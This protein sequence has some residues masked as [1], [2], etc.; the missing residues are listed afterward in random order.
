MVFAGDP[1]SLARD[2]IVRPKERN[3]NNGRPL[4]RLLSPCLIVFWSPCTWRGKITCAL[5]IINVWPILMQYT[6]VR[7]RQVHITWLGSLHSTKLYG[8]ACKSAG[9]YFRSMENRDP[10]V[11][12]FQEYT[13]LEIN[14]NRGRSPPPQI[15]TFFHIQ[16]FNRPARPLWVPSI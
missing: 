9:T 8:A 10:Q 7:P 1:I 3:V 2:N 15:G 5:W 11:F 13:V 12:P 4:I 14:G 6:W 16:C